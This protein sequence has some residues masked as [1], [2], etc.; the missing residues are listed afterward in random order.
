M[1]IKKFEKL[2][3][4]LHDKIENVK[5]IQ[6]SKQALDHGLPLKKLH[7]VIKDIFFKLSLKYLEPL[8][9]R[10][11]QMKMLN[12]CLSQK[13][14]KQYQYIVMLLMIVINEIQE[15]CIHLFL[16]NSLVNYFIFL[17]PFDQEFS[18]IKVWF[19]D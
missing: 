10:Y 17:K 3:V 18:Y 8:K 11:E 2:V 9:V 12:M 13:S 4:N 15:F 5:H 7:R 16:R 19:T 14:L 6:N 1:K